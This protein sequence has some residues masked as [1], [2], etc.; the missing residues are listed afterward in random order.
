L[1]EDDIERASSRADILA[2]LLRKEVIPTV[3][4]IE[5]KNEIL[6]MAEGTMGDKMVF[7][8][9]TTSSIEEAKKIASAL[10]EKRLCA[11]VN[12]Y[13]QVQSLYWWKGKIESSEEAIMI[14]KTRETLISEV[15]KVILE[16][17]SYTCPCI[18]KLLV[19]PVFK[20]FEQWLFEETKQTF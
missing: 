3:V 10:L 17:H 16:N 1:H 19:E 12:I 15:E 18:V 5:A 13:P 8:Y 11:C 2:Q 6:Q 9:V 7:L 4:Y 14:V 20:P